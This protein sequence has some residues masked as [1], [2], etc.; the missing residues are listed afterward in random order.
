MDFGT[1]LRNATRP[2]PDSVAVTCEERQQTYAELFRRA[3]QLAQGLH[4]L[5]LNPGDRVATLGPN[6]FHTAEQ[7][8]G[9]PL[10]GFNKPR[11]LPF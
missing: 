7:I 8:A 2:H 3:C 10:G 11:P 1:I 4:F 5:G 9:L 6:N